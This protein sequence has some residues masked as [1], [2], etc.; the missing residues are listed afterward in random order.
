MEFVAVGALIGFL[1]MAV[2]VLMFPLPEKEEEGD[3][4]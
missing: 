2:V 3:D 1:V 4:G